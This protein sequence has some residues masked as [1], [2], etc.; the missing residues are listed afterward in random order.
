MCYLGYHE[1]ANRLL[2]L[3]EPP[4]LMEHPPEGAMT[5]GL[6]GGTPPFPPFPA[7]GRTFRHMHASAGCVQCVCG[8]E[9][10]Y[11]TNNTRV[12]A[13]ATSSIAPPPPSY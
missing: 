5:T 2:P 7:A 13:Q 8:T 12:F 10:L 3:S 4:V 11:G 1:S 9:L 6:F